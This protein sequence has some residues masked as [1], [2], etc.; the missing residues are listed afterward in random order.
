MNMNYVNSKDPSI[1]ID[2]SGA[3]I[4]IHEQ[5]SGNNYGGFIIEE[6]DTRSI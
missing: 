4:K 1:L 6:V 2:A 5:N 3:L